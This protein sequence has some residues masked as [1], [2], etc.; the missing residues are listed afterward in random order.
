MRG[1]PGGVQGRL[2]VRP[3]DGVRVFLAG[4]TGAIGRRL[5]PLLLEAGHEVTAMTSSHA[6]VEGLRTA[7]AEPVVCDAFDAEA[8]RSAVEAAA[9]EVVVHQL[10]R[11]PPAIDFRRMEEQFATNDRLR[12]EG[13]RNLVEGALAAGARRVIAQ[14]IAFAYEP[15]G[16][17]LKDEEAPL[18]LGAPWPWKRAVEA[19]AELES[20]VTGTEGI[21][22]VVLRY[23]FFYGPGTSYAPDGFFAREARRRRV[24]RVGPATGVFSFIHVDDAARATVAALDRGKPGIYN[25]VDDDPAPAR[26]WIPAYAEAIGAPKPMRVPKLV[27]RLVAG[28][29]A[30][31]VMTE[32]RG[33]S[34][35]KAKR[36]LGWEPQYRSWRQGF[37][38]ANA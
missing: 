15:S 12:R 8:V 34:N 23:G 2:G 35:A 4:A 16:P 22:G 36:E 21:E 30:V 14:S 6:K 17:M 27:A 24:P 38:E 29:H 28:A 3:D 20:T 25:V 1:R 33:A 26:E 7:G 5:L 11:I 32:Q 18:F 31:D 13:T 10:T 37:R 9:P 19:L